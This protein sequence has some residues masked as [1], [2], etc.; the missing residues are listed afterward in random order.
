M[1]DFSDA[2]RVLKQG[3]RVG[4]MGWDDP[5]RFI[6]VQRPDEHSKMTSPYIYTSRAGER[7]PWF[8]SHI[9]ILMDDWVVFNEH[10]IDQATPVRPAAPGG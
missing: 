8:Q 10:S 7:E 6:E 1:L 9:D 4:R 2:L 5:M 3:G